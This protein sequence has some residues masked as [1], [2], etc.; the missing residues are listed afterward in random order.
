MDIDLLQHPT[1]CQT[2]ALLNFCVS[3]G[4]NC[5]TVNFLVGDDEG[6][7]IADQFYNTLKP[8]LIASSP[9]PPAA[10]PVPK[11]Q[12]KAESYRLDADSID[13]ILDVGSEDLLAYSATKKP[14][15][16]TIYRDQ[17]VFLLVASH[18]DYC[19]L[20]G[21]S[22]SEANLFKQLG[23]AHDFGERRRGLLQSITKL[24]MLD[25]DDLTQCVESA[26]PTDTS[27]KDAE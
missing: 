14:E 16:W 19:G 8:F 5:F 21:L 23:I 15:D 3:C 26:F 2:G 17:K 18:D 13:I 22:E 10:G 25:H 12:L 27:Q 20:R 4:A 11:E 6:D 7:R 24:R 1:A 9:Q